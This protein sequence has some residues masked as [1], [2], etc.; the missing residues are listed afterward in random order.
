MAASKASL[1]GTPDSSVSPRSQASPKQ[2]G[3]FP[4]GQKQ[5]TSTGRDGPKLPLRTTHG[6]RIVPVTAGEK[7]PDL[8]DRA[9]DYEPA[10]DSDASATTPGDT[11]PSPGSISEPPSR[12]ASISS[13][14]FRQ[15]S[16]PLLPQGVKK[17]PL[18]ASR[19]RAASPPHRR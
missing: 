5:A 13:I 19:R 15:P 4:A 18:D 16:N 8:L 14:S 1:P 2:E 7:F 3:Y 12:K 10:N 9:K 17:K 6:A 11:A